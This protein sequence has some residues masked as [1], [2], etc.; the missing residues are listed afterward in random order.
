MEW[1]I[2]NVTD[3]DVNHQAL[4]LNCTTT[5][6]FEVKAWNEEGGSLSPLKAWPITTGGGQTL[7]QRDLGDTSHSGI[8][9]LSLMKRLMKSIGVQ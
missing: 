3:P 7:T 1:S 5:Y 4:V 2:I 8:V 6:V 9:L